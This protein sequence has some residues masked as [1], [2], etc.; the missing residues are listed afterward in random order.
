MRQRD[1]DDIGLPPPV[2]LDDENRRA[3]DTAP[4]TPQTRATT[5]ENSPVTDDLVGEGVQVPAVDTARLDSDNQPVR[6]EGANPKRFETREVLP[7]EQTAEDAAFSARHA[8]L[9]EDN[10]QDPI[11]LAPGIPQTAD[12]KWEDALPQS[13][14]LPHDLGE[15]KMPSSGPASGPSES[16]DTFLDKANLVRINDDFS[17]QR[18]PENSAD[19]STYRYSG[20]GYEIDNLAAQ[21]M[22]ISFQEE[23]LEDLRLD[24]EIQFLDGASYV[25]YGIATRF[26]NTIRGIS[27]YGFFVSQTGDC[28]LLKVSNGEETVLADWT[29]SKAFR[30]DKSNLL[31]LECSGGMLRCYVN[32]VMVLQARDNLL[33]AGGYALLAGP[34]VCV[35]FKGLSLVG[36]R[37]G[38][39][40]I[41]PQ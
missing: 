19:G 34:G 37:P 4:Q 9:I 40:Q 38:T 20:G 21:S 22:A 26:T 25:G 7:G 35:Q 16:G 12:T 8:G 32:N 1:V 24:C 29:F 30:A 31:R 33:P 23:R 15:L 27:Y 36:L 41:P 3:S 10:A 13:I 6:S 17:T 11:L 5:P 28:L 18:W 39:V 2:R 14:P